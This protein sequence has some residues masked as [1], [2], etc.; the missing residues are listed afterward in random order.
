MNKSVIMIVL[1]G[2]TKCYWTASTLCHLQPTHSVIN[3]IFNYKLDSKE[4]THVNIQL[5]IVLRDVNMAYCEG[6]ISGYKAVIRHELKEVVWLS[7]SEIWTTPKAIYYWFQR[8]LYDTVLT[9]LILGRLVSFYETSFNTI[10]TNI[11]KCF[12]LLK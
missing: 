3:I 2:E 7:S 11:R 5:S 6:C 1:R 10:I 4:V 8:N 9:V 12:L